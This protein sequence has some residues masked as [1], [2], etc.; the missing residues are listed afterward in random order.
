[1]LSN[2]KVRKIG[3]ATVYV[4]GNKISFL[5]LTFL[6]DIHNMETVDSVACGK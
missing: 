2:S 5:I 4:G 6:H 3:E 1:M